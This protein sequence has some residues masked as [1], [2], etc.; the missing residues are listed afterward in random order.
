[1]AERSGIS[2]AAAAPSGGSGSASWLAVL[3]TID[4]VDADTQPD[5]GFQAAGFGPHGK[6]VTAYSIC[7]HGGQLAYHAKSV[8]NQPTDVRSG[9]VACGASKWH[10][11]SG[12]VF[13]ATTNSWVSPSFPVDRPDAGTTPDDGWAGTARDTTGGIGGFDIYAVC[14]AGMKLRYVQGSPGPVASGHAL[15]RKAMCAANE[16]VVGG[17]ARVTGPADG[18][19]VVT[20][21]PVD[22]SDADKVPDDGWTTQRL[23][24]LGRGQAGHALRGLPRLRLSA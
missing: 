6:A 16:H 13:I 2:S 8:A 15:T 3:Q 5:D 11:T 14:A 22:G 23:Q 12:G 21:A 24:R 10:V 20:S 18:S 1:M 19:R 17:G 7:V 4:Y 9:S